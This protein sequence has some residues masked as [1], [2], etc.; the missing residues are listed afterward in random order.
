MMQKIDW[1]SMKDS[2]AKLSILKRATRAKYVYR[3]AYTEARENTLYSTS[4]GMC[5]F[6]K[7]E[8]EDNLHVLRCKA[9]VIKQQRDDLTLSMCVELENIRTHPDLISMVKVIII[10]EQ[11]PI[12][13]GNVN[14]TKINRIIQEQKLIGTDNFLFG[15]WTSEWKKSQQSYTIQR[16]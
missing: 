12:T 4:N 13:N 3:W 11:T 10:G 2:N 15:L 14:S 6:C 5:K 8:V 16:K 9:T 1:G 7:R